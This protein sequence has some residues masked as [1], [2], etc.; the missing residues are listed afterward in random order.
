MREGF[1]ILGVTILFLVVNNTYQIDK[2]QK[3]LGI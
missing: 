1:F 2:V 3:K